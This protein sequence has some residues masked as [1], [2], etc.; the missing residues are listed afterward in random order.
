MAKVLLIEQV[1]SSSK[2]DTK[3]R[4]TL[5]ALGLRKRGQKVVRSD[6]VAIRGMLNKLH[7][8]IKAEQ[9]DEAE[10]KERVSKKKKTPSYQVA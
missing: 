8:V 6:Y 4:Q 9:L 7:H 5:K 2:L 1:K 3:Q 10:A